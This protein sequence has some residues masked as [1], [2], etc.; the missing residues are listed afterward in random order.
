MQRPKEKAPAE[1]LPDQSRGQS[2]SICT[3]EFIQPRQ[4]RKHLRAIAQEDNRRELEQ[5]EMASY[6]ANLGGRY[7]LEALRAV[8]RGQTIIS[9][10]QEFHTLP[11]LAW[12]AGCWSKLIRGFNKCSLI[13]SLLPCLA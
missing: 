12:P 9:M 13:L 3:N 6:I 7:V 5:I 11:A 10:L 4:E 8:R 2:K 1:V